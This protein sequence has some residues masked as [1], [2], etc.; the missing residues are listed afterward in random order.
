MKTLEQL[1]EERD[2]LVSRIA[3]QRTLVSA[4]GRMVQFDQSHA[5][6]ALEVLDREIA[7]AKLRASGTVPTRSICLTPRSGY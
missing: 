2:A 5:Q 3:S 6:Q 7:Q 4:P 1:Q